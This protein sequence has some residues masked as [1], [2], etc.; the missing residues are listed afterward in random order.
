VLPP[1]TLSPLHARVV[2]G[3]E[4]GVGHACACLQ[5]AVLNAFPEETT[6]VQ[7]EVTSGA[8]D[9]S[10]YYA[11]KVGHSHAPTPPTGRLLTPLPCR[12]CPPQ[13]LAELPFNTFGAAVFS[14]VAYF[15]V[16]LHPRADCFARFV[17]ICVLESTC[18]FALGV[19]ISAAASD[20]ATASLVAPGV[21]VVSFVFGGVFIN[22]DSLPK[23]IRWCPNLSFIKVG[24]PCPH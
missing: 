20:L 2:P 24:I 21:I 4:W 10:A 11:S 19:A 17:A 23:P 3:A 9:L 18:T 1:P 8:Y 7:K 16:G 22:L 12:A 15:P 6:I 13:V 14:V 5:I